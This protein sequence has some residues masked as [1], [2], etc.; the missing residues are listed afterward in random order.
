MKKRILVIMIIALMVVATACGGNSKGNSIGETSTTE[1]ETA[2]EESS[3]SGDIQGQELVSDTAGIS[4][5][6]PKT[7]EENSDKV[8][9]YNDGALVE[10][11]LYLYEAYLYPAS[12]DQLNAMEDEA[13]MEAEEMAINAF[14][15][16][17]AEESQWTKEDLEKWCDWFLDLAPGS[18][19][20]IGTYEENGSKYNCYISIGKDIPEGLSEEVKPIYEGILSDLEGAKGTVKFFEAVDE[21]SVDTGVQLSFTTTD[22]NGNQ[23]TSDEI[24]GAAKFTMVNCWASWCG[25]CIQE[26]PEIEELSKK[27]QEKGGQVVGLLM[28]GSTPLGLEEAKAIIE[29]TGVTYLNIIDWE[30]IKNQIHVQAYPTTYFVDSEGNIV[31]GS[32]IGADPKGYETRMNELLG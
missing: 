5:A 2:T 24:F 1:G 13:Y 6:M 19:E 18:L 29:D 11:G 25:P 21:T 12:L 14:N 3:P 27:V 32:I 20:E 31:G 15:I 22:V 26:L 23:V 30:G 10:E 28:D 16:I 17:K 9:L 7:L 4:I 8:F